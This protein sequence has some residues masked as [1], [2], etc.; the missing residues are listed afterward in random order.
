MKKTIS[1]LLLSCSLLYADVTVND[2]IEHFGFVDFC[3]IG[4]KS[5]PLVIEAV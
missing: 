3:V 2:S 5:I 1:A 4:E